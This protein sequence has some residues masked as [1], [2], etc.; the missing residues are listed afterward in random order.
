LKRKAANKVK[1]RAKTI[2]RVVGKRKRKA[3]I[4]K[5]TIPVESATSENNDTIEEV[6]SSMDDVI[7]NAKKIIG[8]E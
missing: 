7:D 5:S 3:A 6:R 4:K 2:T 8:A 1:T